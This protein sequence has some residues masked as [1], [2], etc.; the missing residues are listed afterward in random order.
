MRKSK[1]LLLTLVLL[2]AIP[3]AA[4][5]SESR[6]ALNQPA[7]AAAT[8]GTPAIEATLMT[9]VLNGAE[10]SPVTNIKLVVKN[11]GGVFYTYITGWATFY[12]SAG[13]RCGAEDRKPGTETWMRPCNRWK[14]VG[15][16]WSSSAT[17]S[18]S[19][20]TGAPNVA[21]HAA[22][23]ATSS[24]NCVDFSLPFRD[25]IRTCA[26]GPGSTSTMAR[27]PSYLGS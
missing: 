6:V 12:D 26:G 8:G 25:H 17:I 22:S 1:L 2:V 19:S 15:W 23:A 7:T 14:P 9:Q 24:G 5:Q 18:P 10:D 16:P 21:A 13:V 20:T 3:V 11:V 27:M 4:Q